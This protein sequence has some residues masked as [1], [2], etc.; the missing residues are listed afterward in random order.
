MHKAYEES[1]QQ[2]AAED[3]PETIPAWEDLCLAMRVAI[4]HVYAAGRQLG[5]GEAEEQH[6]RIDRLAV[7]QG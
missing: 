7:D 6:K 5:A 3:P 4:I 1:R 2:A